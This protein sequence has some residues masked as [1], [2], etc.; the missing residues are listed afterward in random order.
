M[1]FSSL[2]GRRAPDG[3]AVEPRDV[4]R[5][6]VDRLLREHHPEPL[7]ER[8]SAELARIV[9]AADAEAALPA[10]GRVRRA[11]GRVSPGG[12]PR[13]HNRAIPG[14]PV[15]TVLGTR[16]LAAALLVLALVAGCEAAPVPPTAAPA[17][18]TADRARHGVAHHQPHRRR[19]PSRRRPPRRELLPRH[20]PTGP[21]ARSATS[22]SR[23]TAGSSSWSVTGRRTS[24]AWSRSTSTAPSCRDGRGPRA[25]RAIPSPWRSLVPRDPSTSRSAAPRATRRPTPG[26]STA[27]TPTPGSSPGFPVALPEVPFCG[28]AVGPDGTA[29]L[30]CEGEDATTAAGVTTVRAIRPDGSTASGWPIVLQGGGTIN[31]FR[32]DGAVVITTV[33]ERGWRIAVIRPD[34]TSAPGWP[35]GAP[36]GSTVAIDGGGRLHLTSHA[37]SE[38]QCGPA[39]RT[40]YNVLRGDGTKVPGWP[41][42]IR[43]WASEP[44]VADDGSMTILTKNGRAIRYGRSGKVVGGWPVTGVGVSVGC[45]SGSV[46]VSAGK[47]GVV[48]VGDG[49]ATRLT[50]GG[51]VARGWPVDL[52]YRPAITCPGCT[53]GPAGPLAPAIGDRGIYVAAYR[54]DRPRIMALARD[55]ALIKGRQKAIGKKGDDVEWV[56]IAPERPGLDA[57]LALVERDR[58]DLGAAGPGCGGP[59]AQG[60]TRESAPGVWASDAVPERPPRLSAPAPEQ[61]PGMEHG[62]QGDER[63][64]PH[65][66]RPRDRIGQEDVGHATPPG[67]VAF[68]EGRQRAH[69]VVGKEDGRLARDEHRCHRGGPVAAAQRSR[70]GPARRW[71][72]ARRGRSRSGSRG[73]APGGPDS[74]LR[75]RAARATARPRRVPPGWRERMGVEPTARRR[76]PRHWF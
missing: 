60:L 47:D 74:R 1:R 7:D 9:A 62:R 16:R 72:R 76:A 27:S 8:A 42:T 15:M 65:G 54:R 21:P 73:S 40:T 68:R 52:P 30:N 34:G 23:P 32:P 53:P 64:R 46:P 43:G 70:S 6:T 2:T 51:R 59:A 28:M 29:Y 48:A 71:R 4:A 66:D 25:T 17:T 55:G 67:A 20:G 39:T 24:P 49:Q 5:A 31:G 45:Y 61:R 38:G 18:P 50:N 44:L 19:A 37:W 3:T 13:R 35:R 58:V 14:G 11:P 10:P 12:A 33:D 36:V 69:A 75:G 22:G 41:V 56:R 63:R 57:A 26:R